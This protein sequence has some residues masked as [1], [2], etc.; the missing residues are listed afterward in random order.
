MKEEANEW[1]TDAPPDFA[2]LPDTAEV[3]EQC[4]K[5]E[6]L[7]C[8]TQ[9]RYILHYFIVLFFPLFKLYFLY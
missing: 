7:I 2:S 5:L 1:A 8:V 9:E 4:R 6:H 3:E